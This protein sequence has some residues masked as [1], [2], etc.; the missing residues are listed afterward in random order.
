MVSKEIGDFG[1][2]L[3]TLERNSRILC[4]PGMRVSIHTMKIDHGRIHL[5]VEE[6]DIND[7]DDD[8]DDDTDEEDEEDIFDM[9]PSGLL[10]PESRS[11]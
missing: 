8:T 9:E 2:S 4:P 1:V 3:E 5:D 11:A 7:I 10:D 6:E